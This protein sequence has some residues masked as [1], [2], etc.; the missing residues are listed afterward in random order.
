MSSTAENWY[1]KG[2]EQRAAGDVGGA[3]ISFNQALRARPDF[4]EACLDLARLLDAAKQ[5]ST[6]TKM[7]EHWL[8]ILQ[9]GA[10]REYVLRDEATAKSVQT[11][12][13][14]ATAQF[15]RGNVELALAGYRHILQKIPDMPTALLGVAACLHARQRYDD[16]IE[17][18]LAAIRVSSGYAAALNTLGTC[19]RAM[20][21]FSPAIAAY[22]QAIAADPKLPHVWANL[23]RCYCA[24]GDSEQ[25]IAAYEASTSHAT[26][27]EPLVELI[28]FLSRRCEWEAFAHYQPLLAKAVQRGAWCE[29]FKALAYL[30][31]ALQRENTEG[32]AKKYWPHG[33]AYNST[34]PMRNSDRLRIGYLSSD[35]HTHATLALITELFEHHDRARFE[36]YAYSCG[37]DDKSADRARAQKAVDV[38]RDLRALGDQ[39]AAKIIEGDDIDIL[40]EMK[41]HTH[42]QRLGIAALRPAPVAMHYLG[43]PG[44]TGAAFID[45]FITDVVA[46]PKGA[47][48]DFSEKLIRL[49][50]SYQINDRKRALP[51]KTRTR[52]EHGLPEQGF[53]FCDFN[54]A[55]KI[56][57]EIFS[58]WMRI[59][60]G[61][62]NSMLWLYGRQKEVMENLKAAAVK[63]GVDPQR[64]VFAGHAKAAE[65]LERYLHAD[66]CL[67]TFPVCSHTTASD[68]LW[69]GTPLITMAGE[70][71]VNRVAASLLQ[72]VGLPELV[73]KNL[74]DYEQLALLIARDPQRLA[75]LKTHL[76][77]GRK[78]FSLFDSLATTRAIEAAYI[79]VAQLHRNGRSPETFVIP[80]VRGDLEPQGKT[81]V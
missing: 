47:D 26:D 41:G 46:S 4:T 2:K 52:K 80:A 27:T 18:L 36:I 12:I 81:N 37:P 76:A 48:D 72:A 42:D 33:A 51:A 69:C 77:Q 70:S 13:A 21:Q 67:D 34:R 17:K 24:I 66:L 39:E 7:Y 43:Y 35:F 54:S 28:Y 32:W 20:G 1:E 30:P 38:F 60:S 31:H 58:T 10:K 73:T 22:R 29:P 15:D 40:V 8:R 61:V 25:A 9:S 3:I 68:A 11:E 71:F 14:Q 5:T 65:H 79:H 56:T 6:A 59:L 62:E 49:P 45:Y 55:Y 50:M 57:P 63:H 78:K 64:L 23:V 19:Y 75:K 74:A 16:A 44:T 53:V